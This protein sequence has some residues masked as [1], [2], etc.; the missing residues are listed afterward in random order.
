MDVQTGSDPFEETGF[1]S[2]LFYTDP[3]LTHTPG[4]A[5]LYNSL[6][7]YFISYFCFDYKLSAFFHLDIGY[8]FLLLFIR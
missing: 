8:I 5:T 2:H 6:Q 7:M 4:F 1:G 3:N